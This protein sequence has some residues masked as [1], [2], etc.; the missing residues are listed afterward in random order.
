LAIPA[1]RRIRHRGF[2][3]PYEREGRGSQEGAA[4]GDHAV[5]GVAAAA[6]EPGRKPAPKKMSRNA[7][8]GGRRSAMI[9]CWPRLSCQ[10]AKVSAWRS[11]GLR[12]LVRVWCDR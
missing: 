2:E 9:W 8:R 4:E 3:H 6:L 12:R 10:W 7:I 5:A 11:R 1:V